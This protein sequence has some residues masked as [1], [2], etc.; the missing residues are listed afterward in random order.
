MFSDDRERH[1]GLSHHTVSALK[2]GA[3][4]PATVPVPKMSG[5]KRK[6]VWSQIKGSGIEK[7]HRVL[8]VEGEGVLELIKRSGYKPTVM[9]R[10]PSEEPEFFMAAGAAGYVAAQPDDRGH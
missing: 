1:M 4:R 9:G 2:Y 8:E 3:C 10:T 7:T 6:R 5:E